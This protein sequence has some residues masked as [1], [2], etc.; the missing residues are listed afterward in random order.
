MS[1]QVQLRRGN[2]SQTNAFT[3]VVAEVTVDTDKK[4]VVV[5]DGSTAGG[6]PLAK[7]ATVTLSYNHANGAFDRANSANVLAQAAFDSSNTKFASTGGSITGDVSVTGNLTVV[8]QTIYA[9]TQTALIADNII[10]LNAAINQAS[11]PTVDAGFEIDRGSS[12]NV[13][14]LWNETSDKWTFTNDGTNYLNIADAGRLDSVFSLANGTAGVANT[15]FTTISATAGVYGNASFHPVVTLTANG[16]VSS[17]TNTA[18]AID[19]AAITSGTIADA[20]LPTKGTAG[21]YAN[22]TYVPVITTDAYGRVT[23]ITN[24]AIS[25]PAEAD[26][27][28]TVTTRGSTTANAINVT[29]TTSSTSNSTGAIISNGGLGVKGNVYADAVYTN[30]LTINGTLTPTLSANGNTSAY[31]SKHLVEYNPTTKELTYSSTPD[32]SSPYI[33]GYSQEI[34]VSPVAFNDSGKGTIGDPVKTIARAIQLIAPAFETTAVNQRK[35]IVLHPGDYAENVTINTQYTVLTTHELIGKSTT[36][37]GTL[38]LATGCTVAGLKMNNLVISGTSANGSVD[39]IGCT[40][41][42]A[43]TKTSS[44]YTNFRGCDLSSS[45]LSITG[46]GTVVMVGG[47]YFSVTVN[48]AAASVLAKAVVS[49]GP[50]TLTAGTMQISDTLVYALT[51][52]ANAI[53]QSAGSVLT[54]NNSQTL[55]PDLSN[56]ARNS[57]G[58][59]YSILHSVFDKANSTFGGTSLSAI[60][61]SQIINAEKINLTATTASTSNLTGALIV[62][63]GIGVK[64]NVSANGIIFDDGTRQTTAASAGASIGD[65]LALSIALG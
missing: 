24:T 51:N 14:L 2:T 59:F 4:V 54:L 27:L 56:V 9:N 30:N 48:N 50:V 55:I 21:T 47:N 52:T 41:T 31:A 18:I 60:S 28:Q 45:T 22:A 39:I 46:T 33:T 61:Y 7:E 6:T 13:S 35:T 63:G 12:A 62:A 15:D 44:A 36:L 40:V 42:T 19:T 65:V 37:S 38:T 49:M 3:G 58:G 25:F 1:T 11:A 26:T 64:G 34:H 16:R 53:T 5:H 20:R 32:A 29:N 43:V 23:A 10:T 8:G 57:F 17:I